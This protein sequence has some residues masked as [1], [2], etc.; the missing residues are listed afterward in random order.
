MSAGLL[1]S[2]VTRELE[3]LWNTLPQNVAEVAESILNIVGYSVVLAIACL[4][5]YEV[6][7]RTRLYFEFVK[8]SE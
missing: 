6:L 4:F 8:R 7:F 3:G 5:L 2:I 1:D